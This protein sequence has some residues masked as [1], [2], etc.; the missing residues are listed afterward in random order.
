MY[1]KE[2]DPNIQTL[3]GKTHLD[4]TGTVDTL[5]NLKSFGGLSSYAKVGFSLIICSFK[6]WVKT[7]SNAI[8][9]ENLKFFLSTQRRSI[10]C[11]RVPVGTF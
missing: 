9:D 6:F 11:I 8:S 2:P 3:S 5:L 10:V 7:V 4:G 1:R